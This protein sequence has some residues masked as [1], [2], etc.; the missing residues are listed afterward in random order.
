MSIRSGAANGK[1]G[2]VGMPETKHAWRYLA[3][4]R[5]D[6]GGDWQPLR[7][8]GRP[9]SACLLAVLEPITSPPGVP[10]QEE[11][12][13]PVAYCPRQ[14]PLLRLARAALAVITSG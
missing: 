4:T 11:V 12:M 2:P 14:R 1:S 6:L 5:K 10:G 3:R 9:M 7:S 8:I 13:N